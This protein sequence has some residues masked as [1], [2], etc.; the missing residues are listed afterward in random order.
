VDTSLVGEIADVGTV[1]VVDSQGNTV[2]SPADVLT[3]PKL[4]VFK[5]DG[6]LKTDPA[7]VTVFIGYAVRLNVD[8]ELFATE[9]FTGLNAMPTSFVE[10]DTTPTCWDANVTPAPDKNDTPVADKEVDTKGG[11]PVFCADRR[12]VWN[13]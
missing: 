5:A 6:M 13:V 12:L 2:K 3:M 1:V 7:T 4:E 11:L 10:S 8:N 9:I